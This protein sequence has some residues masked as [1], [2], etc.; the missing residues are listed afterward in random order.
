MFVVGSIIFIVVVFISILFSTSVRCF[1]DLSTLLMIIGF[2]ISVVIGTRSFGDLM[3]AFKV[4]IKGSGKQDN[5]KFKKGISILNLLY[6]VTIA[7][8]FLGSIIGLMI[9]M[10]TLDSPSTIGP[11]GSVMLLSI[12]YSFIIAFFFILPAKYILEKQKIDE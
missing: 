9:M 8:G 1:V 5:D 2:N 10:R 11:Y 3:Y 4:I 7:A 6:K 12:L